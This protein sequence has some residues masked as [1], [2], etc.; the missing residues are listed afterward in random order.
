MKK[1]FSYFIFFVLSLFV[2]CNYVDAKELQCVYKNPV[3]GGNFTLVFVDS[4]PS[5]YSH[6]VRKGFS[7][8]EEIASGMYIDA[9]KSSIKEFFVARHPTSSES[10]FYLAPGESKLSGVS[11]VFAESMVGDKWGKN[12]TCPDITYSFYNRGLGNTKDYLYV[13]HAPDDGDCSG[14]ASC[15]KLSLVN[16]SAEKEAGHC[17]F[18]LSYIDYTDTLTITSYSDGS[19][20]YLFSSGAN[21]T[22]D[23]NAEY[24]IYYSNQVWKNEKP[25]TTKVYVTKEELNKIITLGANNAL[26]CNPSYFCPDESY[27]NSFN[28]SHFLTSDLSTCPKDISGNTNY[29][30]VDISTGG[31][32]SAGGT[33]GGSGTTIPGKV[34]STCSEY[35]GVAGQGDNI[36]TFLDGIFGIM[37]VGSIVLVII[38]GMLDFSKALINDKEKVPQVAKK[39]ATR[40]ALLVLLL[41]LPTFIDMIG[42]ILGY[43]D[44]LCGIK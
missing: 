26:T 30:D 36:A 23:F 4:N 29:N 14:Y 12:G 33:G 20:K 19:V 27:I 37:K 10:T 11:W 35:L 7:Q 42:Q 16:N 25:Y 3:D 31:N 40:L 2:F 39:F 24:P 34:T 32:A 38:F 8:V 17:T 9:A 13:L 41:L 28:R 15:N 6:Y 22:V 18:P 1:R 21:G 44:I 5:D 43:E